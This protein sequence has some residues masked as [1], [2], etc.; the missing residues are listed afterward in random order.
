[1]D[2]EA[3]EGPPAIRKRPGMWVGGPV[4]SPAVHG[5]LLEQT[6]CTALDDAMNGTCTRIQVTLHADQSVTVEDDGP[7]FAFELTPRGTPLVEL[8][9]M[10]LPLAARLHQTSP[11]LTKR[12]FRGG[13]IVANALSEWLHLEVRKKGQ[14]WRQRFRCGKPQ[15]PMVPVEASDRTGTRITYRVD[16]ALLPAPI[17]VKVLRACIEGMAA[18]V[19][20]VQFSFKQERAR[21]A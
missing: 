8:I 10:R 1:M 14:L 9:T 6:L 16:S 11:G 12:D 15:G 7:G 21:R 17:R 3:L 4:R 20:E 19:P 18:E 2:I 13:L 5:F